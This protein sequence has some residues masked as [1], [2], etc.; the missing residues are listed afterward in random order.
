MAIP[1]L[2]YGSTHHGHTYTRYEDT[3]VTVYWPE[4]KATCGEVGANE[5]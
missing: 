2:Y 4:L 5:P 3:W 1:W